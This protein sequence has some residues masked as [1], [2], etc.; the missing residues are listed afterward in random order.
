MSEENNLMEEL[1][2]LLDPDEL[3]GEQYAIYGEPAHG[4]TTV[5]IKPFRSGKFLLLLFFVYVHI[6]NIKSAH[7]SK[8][9]QLSEVD[10]I[11]NYEMSTLQSVVEWEFENVASLFP[12][13]KYRPGQKVLLSRCAYFYTVATL[14]KNIHIC[15]NGGQ[16]S[17]HFNLYPPT[18]EEYIDQ[19]K[20]D[21]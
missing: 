6:T 11:I 10:N 4:E 17:E 21:N 9:S 13:V 16:S 12:F 7:F 15:L 5:L 1:K 19:I 3:G 20:P 14:M 2:D 18:L 8:D